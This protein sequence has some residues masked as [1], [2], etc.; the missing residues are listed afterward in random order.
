LSVW[1]PDGITGKFSCTVCPG[2]GSVNVKHISEHESSERHKKNLNRSDS[3][4]REHRSDDE[5][6]APARLQPRQLDAERVRGPLGEALAQLIHQP[7]QDFRRN[8][9]VDEDTGIVDWNSD[10]MDIDTN[11]QPSLTARNAVFLMERLH[12]YL[13]SPA[14]DVDSDDE[15]EERSEAGSTSSSDSED[16]QYLDSHAIYFQNLF[17]MQH[18]LR[19]HEKRPGV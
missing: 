17:L 5:D 2:F 13:N 9:W 1:K 10:M 11:M 6:A 4:N 15:P 16:S 18:L 19:L 7:S 12:A 8:S 3:S 14:I